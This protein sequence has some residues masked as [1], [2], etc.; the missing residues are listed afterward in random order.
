MYRIVFLKDDEEL[1]SMQWP[2]K[3][4]AIAQALDHFPNQEKQKGVTSVRVIDEDSQKIV[5]VH[6]ERRKAPRP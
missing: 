1:T 4:A 6:P 2:D 5:F 3:Q